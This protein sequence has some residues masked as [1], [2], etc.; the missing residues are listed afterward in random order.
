MYAKVMVFGI[1]VVIYEVAQMVSDCLFDNIENVIRLS[2]LSCHEEELP[3]SRWEELA[4]NISDLF[5]RFRNI[6]FEKLPH[7]C[8][9]KLLIVIFGCLGNDISTRKI[10]KCN[11]HL[12]TLAQDLLNSFI[13]SFGVVDVDGLLAASLHECATEAPVYDFI[14]RESA[15][16][17]A[18]LCDD[19]DGGSLSRGPLFRDALVWT[20]CV[21]HFPT[22]RDAQQLAVLHPL[23]LQLIEDYRCQLKVLGLKVLIHL[24]QEVVVASWRTTGRAEATLESLTCQRSIHSEN[25]QLVELTYDCIS[26]L[27]PLLE[28]TPRKR[29]YSKVVDILLCD[30]AL[31]ACLNKRIVLLRHISK[32]IDVL[33][34]EILVHS[35]RLLKAA[36][37]S[38]LTPRAPPY[39]GEIHSQEH[40]SF[41]LQ[42][43][44]LKKYVDLVADHLFPDIV[45]MILPL[46]VAFIDLEWSRKGVDLNS[47][48]VENMVHIII[49]ILGKLAAADATMVRDTLIACSDLFPSINPVLCR[50]TFT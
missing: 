44:I 46:I 41:L 26:A 8:L 4:S 42:L 34:Q 13:S 15:H 32:L 24:T 45:P 30:L 11:A 48:S 5:I 19:S 20:T 16:C 33:G 39:R 47:S 6:D 10:T 18:R 31:E 2:S 27:I 36:E 22:L 49:E 23:S 7:R 40:E 35:R 43:N 37:L 3:T 21:V 25:A 38:L 12:V 1:V 9:V 28:P 50:S 29:W 14:L 17:I